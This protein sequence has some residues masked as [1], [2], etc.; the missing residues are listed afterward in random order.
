MTRAGRILALATLAFMVSSAA[1]QGKSGA[2]AATETRE[3]KTRSLPRGRAFRSNGNEYRVVGGVRA[4]Q[5]DPG[6]TPEAV[7]AAL[8][9]PDQEIVESKGRYTIIRGG[10]ASPRASVGA[11]GRLPALPVAVNMATGSLGVLTGA[12]KVSYRPPFDPRQ[13]AG[14]MGLA[15][16]LVVPRESVAYFRVP[17]RADIQEAADALARN[18]QVAGVSTEVQEY[19]ASPH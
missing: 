6:Q 3:E 12:I 10:G 4:V 2:Q 1:A 19:F 14:E 15:I 16:L 8:G 18:P 7:A 13:V 17:D 9:L 5:R 11:M